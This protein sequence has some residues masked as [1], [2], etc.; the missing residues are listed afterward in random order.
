MPPQTDG[1]SLESST[2]YESK[3]KK[4]MGRVG[5][6][7]TTPAMSRRYPNQARPPAQ[8][9]MKKF[10]AQIYVVDRLYMKLT[11]PLP[12]FYKPD[13]IAPTKIR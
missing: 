7:P 3:Y 9:T 10:A 13:I 2:G 4:R 6:E 11:N 8:Y 12:R 5:V 1:L